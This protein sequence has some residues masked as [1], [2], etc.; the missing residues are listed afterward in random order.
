MCPLRFQYRFK[1]FFNS[2]HGASE[3]GIEFITEFITD[4]MAENEEEMRWRYSEMPMRAE[5]HNA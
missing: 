3:N 5:M 1:R 4:C 2:A